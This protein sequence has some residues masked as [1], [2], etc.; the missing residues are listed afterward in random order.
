MKTIVRIA[1][2]AAALVLATTP[3]RAGG[4]PVDLELV[5]AIDTSRSID[6][7]EHKLQIDGYARALTDPD[8]LKAVRSGVIG[9]IAVTMVEWSGPAEQRVMVGWTAV[10][11]DASASAFAAAL[12]GAGRSFND[13]TSISGGL[14]FSMRLFGESGFEGTRRVI[15]VS[16]DGV[17][18]RGRPP[19]L[20]RD[21]AVAA[22]MTI[23]GLAIINDRPSRLPYPE[24]PL[25]EYFRDN[26]IGGPGAFLIVVKDFASFAEAV[27]NKLIREISHAPGPP[28][29]SLATLPAVPDDVV[30][31]P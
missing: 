7:D 2:A 10:G 4:V 26:V 14:D 6:E 12:R 17:N 29:R 11:D 19:Q 20:S 18:N 9:T 25:D 27:R 31:G 23:N 3:G 1:M 8:V 5:L 13:G 24:P 16:A 22:G 30:P 28:D 21:E 15:D